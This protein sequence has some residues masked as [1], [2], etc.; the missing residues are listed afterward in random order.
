MLLVSYVYFL[1]YDAMFVN[2]STCRQVSVWYYT[3]Q[4]NY[5]FDITQ[6]N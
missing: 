2:L 4:L 5:V 6:T 3:D 1:C